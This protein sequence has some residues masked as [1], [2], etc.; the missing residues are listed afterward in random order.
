MK[1]RLFLVDYQVYFLLHGHTDKINPCSTSFD[2]TNKPDNQ[3][4]KAWFSFSS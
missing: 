3:R 2:Y 1:T 4:G